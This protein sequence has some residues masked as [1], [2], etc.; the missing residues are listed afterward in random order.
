MLRAIVEK[1]RSVTAL[2]AIAREFRGMTE[3]LPV[4]A[5][6]ALE[7]ALVNRFDADPEA[8]R[9]AAV[10]AKVLARGRILSEREYR[11]V[12]TH[13]ACLPRDPSDA[14]AEAEYLRLGALLDAFMAGARGHGRPLTASAAWPLSPMLLPNAGCC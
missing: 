7:R 8:A 11:A 13:G 3:A 1:A 14:A 6:R 4:D 12:E 10:A 5:R 9:D 2:K